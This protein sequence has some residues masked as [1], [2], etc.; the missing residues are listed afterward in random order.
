MLWAKGLFIYFF[1]L[2]KGTKGAMRAATIISKDLTYYAY[3]VR[4][5]Y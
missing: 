3:L 1:L 2:L 4:E 5:D